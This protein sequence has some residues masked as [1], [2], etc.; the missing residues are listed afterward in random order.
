MQF[1]PSLKLPE[2]QKLLGAVYSTFNYAL[3]KKKKKGTVKNAIFC[4]SY[5][6]LLA[7]VLGKL[8]EPATRSE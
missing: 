4:G 7:S 5:V 8:M 2:K 1:K 3:E 6:L